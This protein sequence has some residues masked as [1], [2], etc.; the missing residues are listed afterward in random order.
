MTASVA[1]IWRHPIKSHGREQLTSV[2]LAPGTTLPGD[3]AWAMAH[4]RSKADGSEWVVCGNFTTVTKTIALQAMTAR[5]EA[6]GSLSLAHP[7]LGELHFDPKTQADRLI[8]WTAP[9]IPA[10][11][12][13]SVRLIKLADR[14]FTDTDFPSVSLLNLA[15]HRAVEGVTGPISP[16]RWRGN[17]LLDGLGPWEE[18]EWVGRKLRLGEAELEIRERIIRCN[19]TRVD[20]ATGRRDAD[21]LAALKENW[22]HQDFGVYAYVARGGLVREGD[23]PEVMQ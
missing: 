17:F 14:G 5:T 7:D 3:R 18:F 4:D 23:Q 21:T 1:Q 11:R 22:G 13:A 16:L 20:P 2:T 6:D 15:S 8:D 12:P 9:L 10:D 19:A